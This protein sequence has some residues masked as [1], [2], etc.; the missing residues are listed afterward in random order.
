MNCG[1]C[2]ATLARAPNRTYLFC[3]YCDTFV[4]PDAADNDGVQSLRTASGMDCPVCRK[5]L[6]D[7]TL[8]E[9]PVRHCTN[10][11]GVLATHDVFADVVRIRRARRKDE[12]RV[13]EPLDARL[14]ERSLACPSCRDVMETHPYYGPGPVV[15]D[16]CARCGLL[17]LD[18]GELSTI[19][20]AA[21]RG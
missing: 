15:I 7:G 21:G 2:G 3:S 6:L 12:Q 19:E 13:H 14:L 1:N 8:E 5:E 20:T 16:T 18:P 17:W 10:C 11:R 4:F 9:R